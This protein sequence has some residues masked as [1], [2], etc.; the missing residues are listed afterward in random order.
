MVK[1]LKRFF[2]KHSFISLFT[3]NFHKIDDNFY[4]S[5]QPT[6]KHLEEIIKK[7]NIKTVLNVRG[8]EHIEILASQKEICKKYNVELITIKLHSRGIPSKEKINRL[9]EILTTSKYP[10]L[11]HCKSGSDR[12]GLVATLYCHWIKGK[13]IKEIK[14]LKAFPY[15]HFKH[16]K[17]GLIDKYFEE[18][19]KFKKDNPKITLIE[20]TN[21]Y[22]DKEKIEK[23]FKESGIFKF[24]VDKILRR[25]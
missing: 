1:F 25:E 7:Y 11:V 19:L 18:Y 12:T 13:D 24:L 6:D 16:S 22:M 2:T 8:E 4:R 5:A 3:F 21:K 15:L 20:W 10:M 14:Q 17:T 9:Y 23:D